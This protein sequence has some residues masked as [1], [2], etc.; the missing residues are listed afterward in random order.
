MFTLLMFNRFF[1]LVLM[2][3]WIYISNAVALE[4]IALCIDYLYIS[5]SIKTTLLLLLK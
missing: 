5:C 1:L 2:S 4:F 3:G